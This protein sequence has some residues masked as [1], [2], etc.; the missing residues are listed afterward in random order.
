[1]DRRDPVQSGASRAARA[2]PGRDR[3]IPHRPIPVESSGHLRVSDVYGHSVWTGLSRGCSWRV[4]S[5]WGTGAQAST[6]LHPSTRHSTQLTYWSHNPHPNSSSLPRYY[7]AVEMLP[8]RPRLALAAQH[9]HPPPQG[10]SAAYRRW[11]K[12]WFAIEALPI[13]IIVGSALSAGT[14]LLYR[15]TK[16]P[17]GE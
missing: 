15:A 17:D 9:P 8:T 14:W 16:R 4:I 10:F 1:M 6:P 5:A 3:T 12:N 13:V 7:I 2:R 11:H